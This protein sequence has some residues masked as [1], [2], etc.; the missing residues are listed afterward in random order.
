M[1]V[2]GIIWT[3]VA[4][5]L[6]SLSYWCRYA[7]YRL[8]ISISN[9]RP[10][11][12]WHLTVNWA[13]KTYN[14]GTYWSWVVGVEHVTVIMLRWLV[15]VAIANRVTTAASGRS[16]PYVQAPDTIWD[17]SAI[18]TH[19]YQNRN[20]LIVQVSVSA[21]WAKVV[22][23]QLNTFSSP[24]DL[25]WKKMP[26]AGLD[27]GKHFQSA[28]KPKEHDLQTQL[29]STREVSLIY[30]SCLHG[31]PSA[32]EWCTQKDFLGIFSTHERIIDKPQRIIGGVWYM[33]TCHQFPN[34]LLYSVT[35]DPLP[36]SPVHQAQEH[37]LKL[38]PPK[39]V[40]NET[41]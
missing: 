20:R 34:Y 9:C 30:A 31:I 7:W 36:V 22:S 5:K 33:M 25:A 10:T 37:G 32:I 8:S 11:Y 26:L 4:Q 12:S 24:R 19:P 21:S 23:V 2:P 3:S 39:N 13:C 6:V 14:T 17:M 18:A 29:P 1:K 16:S 41:Q 15:L 35:T 28:D 40:S 27:T 38:S